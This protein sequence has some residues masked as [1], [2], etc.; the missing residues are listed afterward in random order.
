MIGQQF[1]ID[2]IANNLANVNTPGFKR[3]RADF[4]D[5][6]YHTIRL[7]GTPSTSASETPTG[8]QV[9]H[10]TQPGATQ[11][12]YTMGK[13]QTTGNKL[14][15]AIHGE[16]FF[17]IRHSDGS[18]AYTRDGSFKLDSNGQIVTSNGYRL[19]PEIVLPEGF[20]PEELAV[21]EEGIVTVKMAETDTPIEVG[22]IETYRF[23]NP[24]GLQAIGDNLLKETVG[25]GRAV[26]GEPGSEGFGRL[27]QGML[28]MSNV[29]LAQEM[30]DMIVAQ[31]AYEINS[32]TIITSDAML[33]T[34]V[35]L[36]R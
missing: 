27:E 15:I 32:K 20:L 1:S 22:R 3:A 13:L 28:E 29:E 16:G 30:V 2:T 9:G 8:I 18:E 10:G 36:K 5:L 24:A 34:A 25:S 4:E 6:L 12:M 21:S 31:R 17:K 19:L 33:A 23:V 11:K 14:D 7:A 35:G 26:P